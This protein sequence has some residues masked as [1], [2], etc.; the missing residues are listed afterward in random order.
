[1]KLKAMAKKAL[2]DFKGKASA[3]LSAFVANTKASAAAAIMATPAAQQF[4][5]EETKRTIKEYLPFIILAALVL[6]FLGYKAR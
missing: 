4:K 5:A 2:K 1:M 6:V 3:D